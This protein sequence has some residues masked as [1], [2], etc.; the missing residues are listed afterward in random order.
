MNLELDYKISCI[1]K[2]KEIVDDICS[3]HKNDLTP[4]N[5]EQL[6]NYLIYQ[7]E[8]DE[9]KKRKILTPNRMAT[10]NKRE[11]SLEGVVSKFEKNKDG[12][13]N[14]MNEDKNVILTPKVSITEE[15]IKK[16]PFIKQ[17]RASIKKLR[18]IKNKNYIIQ[19][20]II[21]LS[22]TQY[23]IK[24]AYKKTIRVKNT[25]V[26]E[27][28][29]YDWGALLNFEDWT[30][31]RAMLQTYSDL[32][33]SSDQKIQEG[34]YWLLKDFERLADSA[35]EDKEPL[36]YDI[37]KLKIVKTP[38]LEVQKF[39]EQEYGH[40]YS[41]EYISSLFNNKIPKLIAEEEKCRKLYFRYTYIE[42]GQ[43]KRCTRCGQTKL[44]HS[45]FFS[46]NS[47]GKNGFY[48]ICKKCRNS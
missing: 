6:A 36:L 41:V 13:Y 44:M 2:R 10:V 15:D 26:P 48:S 24:E 7:M 9:R 17:V 1:N 16:I 28:P 21:N 5:L 23:I 34:I 8:K 11:T 37:L 29:K 19:Q 3:E 12:V 42:K 14:I 45:M 25:N 4:Y 40:T 46:K 27:K 32:K 39:L 35:L 18:G 30:V 43:W 33:N 22:Q 20:A 47:G 38:N 31:V